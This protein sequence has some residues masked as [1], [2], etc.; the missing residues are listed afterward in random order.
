[1]E[2]IQIEGQTATLLCASLN[3]RSQTQITTDTVRRWRFVDPATGEQW[4]LPINP[5]KMSPIPLGRALVFGSS[6]RVG[7]DRIRTGSRP[8]PAQ[9]WSFGGVIRTREH[10]DGLY[11]WALRGSKIRV[12]D[13][14]GR[15]FEV[16]ITDFEPAARKPT[17]AVPWRYQ[18]EMKTLMMRRLR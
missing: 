7:R 10:Y 18:Y 14:L 15:I 3:G 17:P 4:Q 8:Q 1:M 12:H 6:T 5:N 9:P 2:A 13:H 16:V 11:E